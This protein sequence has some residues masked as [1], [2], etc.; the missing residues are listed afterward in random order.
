MEHQAH[1]HAADDSLFKI[2]I[3]LTIA[4]LLSGAIIAGTYAVTAPVAAKERVN[5]KNKAMQELVADAQEFK[6]V[7]GKTDWYAAIRDGKTIAYVVPAESKGYGGAIKMLAAVSPDGKA[8]EYKILSH[9]ET[10]GLG[11]KA[12]EPKFG[13]QFAGKKAEDLE[14]VKVPT[15]KNIQALT[16]ATI[17]SRAVTKG[18]KEAVEQVAAYAASQGK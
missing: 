12:S 5:L 3:N 17:T 8:I 6:P 1:G 14:V 13:K 9:N 2:G 11:D 18:I 15:D 4:C 16:G 10:P 7:S